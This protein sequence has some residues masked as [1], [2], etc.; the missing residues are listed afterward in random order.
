MGWELIHDEH[1]NPYSEWVVPKFAAGWHIN[2]S[3]PGDGGN[4]VLSGHHNIGNEVFRDLI[5]L[6][7]GH[8]VE[9]EAGDVRYHY[10]VEEKYI[11]K[12]EGVSA[13]VR[14]ANYRFIEPTSDERLTLVSCW[15]YESNSHR[16]I[17]IARP[18]KE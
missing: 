14:E 11:V 10:M 2:S 6:E 12:E 3:L 17:V 8:K 4:T 1:G 18:V 5:Q 9:I 15:P 7:A 16:V 13:E